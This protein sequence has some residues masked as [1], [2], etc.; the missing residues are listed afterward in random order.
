MVQQQ[1]YFEEHWD[2][3]RTHRMQQ[4]RIV[5]NDITEQVSKYSV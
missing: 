5:G 1:K 4:Y 2:K 3:K